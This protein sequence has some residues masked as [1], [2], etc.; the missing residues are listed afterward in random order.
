ME[1]LSCSDSSTK[2]KRDIVIIRITNADFIINS[3]TNRKE[4]YRLKSIN[5]FWH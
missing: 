4:K 1:I 3:Q 5:A 2:L